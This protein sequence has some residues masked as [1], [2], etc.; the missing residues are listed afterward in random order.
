MQ[1]PS[2]VEVKYKIKD[3]RVPGQKHCHCWIF[4]SRPPVKVELIVGEVKVVHK[5][6]DVLWNK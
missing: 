2:P 1:P 5:W 4:H 3:S 6:S